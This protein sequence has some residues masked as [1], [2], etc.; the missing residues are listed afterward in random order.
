MSTPQKT[1]IFLERR[2]Y[3]QRR[4]IDAV[5][6]LP[7]LGMILLALPLLWQAEESQSSFNA[8]ALIYVFG[9]WV[10][11]IACSAFVSAFMGGNDVSATTDTPD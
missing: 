11:L 7:I 6:L 5:R 1:A 9:V 2:G 4:L 3:R 10:L 8:D